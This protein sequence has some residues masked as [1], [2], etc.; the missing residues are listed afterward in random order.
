MLIIAPGQEALLGYIFN[1][2]NHEGMLRV[3]IRIAF[4]PHEGNSNE[5]TQYTFSPHEKENHSKLSKTC[6]YGIFSKGPKNKFET[7][8]ENEPSVF[9]PLKVYC[10]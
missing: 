7:A 1:F 6:I 9:K 5:S 4:M 2:L 3:L 10:M 8:V